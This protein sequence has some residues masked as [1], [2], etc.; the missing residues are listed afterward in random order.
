MR[1]SAINFGGLFSL[2]AF[3]IFLIM[4]D[5]FRQHNLTILPWF[6]IGINQSLY[7]VLQW[8]SLSYMVRP[9]QISTAYGLVTCLQNIGCTILPPF[10]SHLHDSNL[11][12]SDCYRWP[13]IAMLT[14]A[15][16]SFCLKIALKIWDQIVRGGI[17]DKVN[18]YEEYEKWLK[19]VYQEDSFCTF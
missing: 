1:Q 14:L 12:T 18:A 5:T 17:L 9:A 2:A 11:S 8:G 10:I 16:I 19:A 3:L 6:F 7:Y 4:P 15:I 13:M